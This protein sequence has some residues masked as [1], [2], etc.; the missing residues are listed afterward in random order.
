MTTEHLLVETNSDGVATLTLNRPESLNSLSMELE[1]GLRDTIA[2]LSKDRSVRVVVI[3]GSGR[4]FCAGG[5]VKSMGAGGPWD[6][7]LEGRVDRL[8]Q[9][10]KVGTSLQAMPQPT[11][12]MVNGVAAGAGCNLALACDLRIASEGAKFTL[13]FRNVGLA[14]DLG[15]AWFLP[16][17]AGVSKALELFFTGEVIDAEEALRIGMVNRV[18]PAERLTAET[19]ALAGRLAHGPAEALALVKREVYGG[20]GQSL[21]ELLDIEAEEQA[22]L[23]DAVDHSEGIS[24]FVEKRE[25]RFQR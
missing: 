14:D 9:L 12:A 23:M 22:K 18:V 25:A 15:G 1:F 19:Y 3:T 10:H 16:R 20:L 6:L 2:A 13:A 8:K 24:A 17:L 11:I 4:A 7:P 21:Q 5:D